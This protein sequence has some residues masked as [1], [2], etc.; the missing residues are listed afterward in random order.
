MAFNQQY[1]IT[2]YTNLDDN[3]SLSSINGHAC[4]QHHNVYQV[5]YDFLEKEKPNKILEIGTSLGGF[6]AYINLVSKDL[7]INSYIRS[8]DICD[9]PWF[10]ELKNSGVDLRIENIFINNYSDIDMDV[11]EMIIDNAKI[12]VLCDG[13]NKKGEF[14]I[15]AKYM[16]PGDIIMAHDYAPNTEY[17]E[18][19]M[20]NKIWNWHEIQDS[21]I[22]DSCE[23]YGLKPYMREEFLSVAWCCFKKE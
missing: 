1:I 14:N 19:Y 17:F 20:R 2:K 18:Q 8:Y 10:N 21:D 12:I 6:T 22:I 7:N 15:F 4:Q 9:K 13:G 5:F 16:K 11:K 3:D 23:K